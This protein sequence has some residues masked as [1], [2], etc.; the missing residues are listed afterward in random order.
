MLERDV[1]KAQEH[2][3]FSSWAGA[4][5][6][7]ATVNEIQEICD[8]VSGGA[9]PPLG[10]RVMHSEARLSRQDKELLCAWPLQVRTA[11]L[12]H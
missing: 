10:Y 1:R 7:R 11:R 9:M 12:G 8:A 4:S 3:D 2:L 5:P 6:H